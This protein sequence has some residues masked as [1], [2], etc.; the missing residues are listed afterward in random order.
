MTVTDVQTYS[1]S[2]F[3]QIAW[4]QCDFRQEMTAAGEKIGVYYGIEAGTSGGTD[5]R[6]FY[7]MGNLDDFR[8][9]A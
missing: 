1:L 9:T 8:V 4:S 6:I 2:D 3:L 7:V 5:W